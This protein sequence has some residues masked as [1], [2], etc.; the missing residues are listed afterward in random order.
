MRV[1]RMQFH[2]QAELTEIYKNIFAVEVQR[3]G[4]AKMIA[5]PLQ[6]PGFPL[7]FFTAYHQG[8]VRNLFRRVQFKIRP[9]M[10]IIIECPA[11]WTFG[12][13]FH[14]LFLACICMFFL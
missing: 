3:G 1:L 9:G 8:K 5:E 14:R 12:Q 2:L 11:F 13:V 6:M 4:Q 7:P 10:N